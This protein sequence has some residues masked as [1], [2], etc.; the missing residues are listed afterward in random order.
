MKK[1][2]FLFLLVMSISYTYAQVPTDTTDLRAKINSWVV[3]NGSK[4]ITATQINQLFNGIANLMKAYAID[5]G[6]RVADTLFLTRRG[7]TAIKVTLN[8][9]GAPSETDPTVPTIA[10][11]L[12]GSDTARWNNK[13]NAL[14]PGTGISIV[15]NVISAETT[16]AQWNAS[17]LQGNNI[18]S[19]TPLTGQV[20]KWNGSTWA[21]DTDSLGMKDGCAVQPGLIGTDITSVLQSMISSGCKNIHIPKGTYSIGSTIQMKDSVTIQGEGRATVLN[22]TGNFPAFK[23]SYS[24]GGNKAQFRDLS[25][26]GTWGTGTIAQEGIFSD[27][28]NGIFITNIS[29]KRMAG[30]V[31]RLRNNGFCCGG[32]PTPTGVLGNIVSDCW[33]DSCYGGIKHDTLGEFN[34]TVNCTVVNGTYGFFTA[35]GSSRFSSCNGSGL[36]YGLII[37]GGANNAHGTIVNSHFAHCWR[38]GLWVTGAANGYEIIGC[39]IR[40][41]SITIENSDNIRFTSC[42]LGTESLNIKNSTNVIFLFP[43]MWGPPTYNIT[44]ST[45]TMLAADSV[46]N[47]ISLIDLANGKRFDLSQTNGLV[48]FAKTK[49]G[50]Y[51]FD[52][53]L[54]V[55]NTSVITGAHSAGGNLTLTS[56]STLTKGKIKLGNK[57]AF[58]EGAN[59]LGL[60]TNTPGYELDINDSSDVSTTA[61]ITDRSA[62]VN[63]G[64]RVLL[65]NNASNVGQIFLGGSNN[66]FLPNGMFF[67]SSGN[68]ALKFV[69]TGGGNIVFGKSLSQN[70]SEFF[71]IP[72]GTGNFL[73]NTLTDNASKGKFQIHSTSVFDSLVRINNVTAPPA[74]YSILV[75]SDGSDSGV[76]KITTPKV[77]TAL[78]SQSGTSNPTAVILGSNTIGSIVWTRNSTGNYTGTLTGA[79]ASNKTWLAI[80]KGDGI[81]SFING[82]LSRTSADAV[83]LTTS[84]NG[85]TFSDGFNNISI[86]IRVYP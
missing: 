4:Q 76:Y 40:Q 38:Q 8:T 51:S 3:T 68:G 63:A 21:P 5:S 44:S 83:L 7:Y 39:N 19:A 32:Y 79:F 22:V 18:S 56:T 58:D 28:A 69:A 59:W 30:W 26:I 17:Q 15:A 64:A 84:D 74:A 48:T 31:I 9:G 46:T 41:D 37:T 50:K 65:I 60:G 36:D 53:T 16:I 57:S 10:K 61:A 27:S 85:G 6:Y 67:H 11:S 29:A 86:E 47:G 2:F 20:L 78:L 80:S 45:V 42:E 33:I 25:F 14:I 55:S 75:H 12:T 82:L 66:A 62:S 13:Q 24:L 70:T 54:E 49:V 23:C 77:Y 34:S 43:R 81:G 52:D 73:Y 71:R 35:A 72:T 1:L